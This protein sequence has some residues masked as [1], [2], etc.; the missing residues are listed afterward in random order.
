MEMDYAGM[1]IRS[2]E[3]IGYDPKTKGFSSYVYS[4]MA[5]DPLPYEW[6]LDGD[7]LSISVKHGPMNATFHGK[8]APDG[9]SFSGGWRPNPGADREINAPYDVTATRV[10]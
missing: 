3:I 7:D 5:P 6:D 4:N 8:M 1:P 9:K 10:D 2:R